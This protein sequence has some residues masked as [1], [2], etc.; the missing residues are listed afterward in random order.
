MKK[1]LTVLCCL[2]ALIICSCSNDDDWDMPADAIT[3]NMMNEENGKTV[4]G[5]SDLYINAANNFYTSHCGITEANGGS[6]NKPALSQLTHEI[7]VKP[8]K[9]YQVFPSALIHTFPSGTYAFQ[10]NEVFYNLRVENFIKNG[11]EITGAVVTYAETYPEATG[12]PQWDETIGRLN[13]LGEIVSYSFPKG[14]EIEWEGQSYSDD[15]AFD[16]TIRGN[17]LTV[18]LLKPV[19]Q[20]SGPYGWFYIYV[21]NGH[22]FTRVMVKVGC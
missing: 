17:E 3:L 2:Y 4:L 6:Y 18:T 16:I 19:N 20:V 21:R 14:S 10:Q 11:D 22:T 7:A 9:R 1:T 15:S 13:N 12:L 5:Q 8:G